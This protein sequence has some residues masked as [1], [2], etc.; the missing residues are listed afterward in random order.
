MLQ[1]NIVNT[2]QHYNISPFQQ[3]IVEQDIIGDYS[4]RT[5]LAQAEADKYKELSNTY[6]LLRLGVFGLMVLSV[7]LAVAYDDFTIL[8]I[9]FL[10]LIGCFLWLVSRQS[11]FDLQR[12]Y[13]NN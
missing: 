12:D 11:Q 6:S 2:R 3:N 5:S 10:V 9:A 7:C 4:K 8:A 13:F 1:S